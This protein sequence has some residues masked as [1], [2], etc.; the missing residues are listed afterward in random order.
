MVQRRNWLPAFGVANDTD[1]L[2]SFGSRAL[3]QFVPSQ[4]CSLEVRDDEAGRPLITTSATLN[5]APTG[6]IHQGHQSRPAIVH[7]LDNL[8]SSIYNASPTINLR[9][10]HLSPLSLCRVLINLHSLR[11][12]SIRFIAISIR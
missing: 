2:A 9:Y 12:A 5:I 10:L 6:Q 1:F 4:V 11:L 7:G 3:R 8:I